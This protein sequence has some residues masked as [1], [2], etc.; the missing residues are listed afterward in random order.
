MHNIPC[1]V[2]GGIGHVDSVGGNANLGLGVSLNERL[3]LTRGYDRTVFGRLAS[4][5]NLL[6]ITAPQGTQIMSLLI[7]GT[8]EGAL[9]TISTLSSGMG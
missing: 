9:A 4:V 6:L 5:S 1:D 3:S 2:G 8:Y 7:G